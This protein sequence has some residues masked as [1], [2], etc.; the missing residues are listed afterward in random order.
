MSNIGLS[1]KVEK[2]LQGLID[3]SEESEKFL[4]YSVI[5][6]S[7]ELFAKLMKVLPASCF[8]KEVFRDIYNGYFAFYKKYEKKPEKFEVAAFLLNKNSLESSQE[9]V[10]ALLKDM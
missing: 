2:E 10:Q 9:D 4:F 8:K 3:S 7:D 1:A 6:S 5:E